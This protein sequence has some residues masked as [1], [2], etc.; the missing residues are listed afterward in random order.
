MAA[1]PPRCT[2][3]NDKGSWT[4]AT[5]GKARILLSSQPLKVECVKEGFRPTS[6]TLKCVSLHQQSARRFNVHSGVA[7]AMIPLAVAAAPV[8]PPAAAQFAMYG[9]IH[10]AGAAIEHRS[11]PTGPNVC[12]YVGALVV[13]AAE[14]KP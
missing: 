11:S 14:P 1:K 6:E 4:V 13:L 9:V 10:G 12:T 5:P 7:L 2:L 3:V 8:Y